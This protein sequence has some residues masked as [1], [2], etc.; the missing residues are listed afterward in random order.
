MA[1]VAASGSLRR[2]VLVPSLATAVALAVLILLG[3]WQLDRKAW[4]E[5]LIAI[6]EQRLSAAPVALPP[7]AEWP[8]LTAETDEFLRVVMTAE[9]L[10]DRE[11]LVYTGGS[12]LRE[13]SG[14]PGYWIFT[15]ARLAGGALI[16]VNR[17]FVPDGKQDPAAR[18]E[19]QIVS[20]IKL[21][22]VLRWPEKPGP[23]TPAGDP[24][25]NI[26][27][28][29]E[30]TAIAAA[31]AIG[32][33]PFYVEL[34]SPEP[35]GGL[36]HTGRLRPNLPNN[37]L[38]YALTWFGLAAVLLAVYGTWLFGSWRKRGIVGHGA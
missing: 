9:F 18:P 37:H 8:R 17:G 21:V 6:L 26:W 7:P 25:R 33:A 3:L 4:K 29:R 1:G 28:A 32:G 34:E 24:A 12:T 20:P 36:P 23:F 13:A 31:K 19:G 14:G 35:P 5:G 16:M 30:S 22:G 38:G 15:P 27:F 2:G 11:A 10:N